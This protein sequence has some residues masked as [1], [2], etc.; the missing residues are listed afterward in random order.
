MPTK[1]YW[2]VKSEPSVYSWESLVREKRTR[3][4]GVRNFEARNN[5]RAMRKGDVVLYYHS[6]DGKEI[7]GVAKVAAEASADPTAK[8]GD[9]SAVDLAPERA[10]SRPVS[11]AALKQDKALSK[12]AVVH[13]PRI[14]VVPVLSD[15]LARILELAE[16]KL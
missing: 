2:L 4:D 14:S 6:G 7:V 15:E 1:N 8:D 3:W 10:L 9:W 12:M 5:L 13:K 16:S 11:L